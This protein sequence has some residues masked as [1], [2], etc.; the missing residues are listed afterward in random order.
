[1]KKREDALKMMKEWN[2]NQLNH[3]VEGLMGDW[4]RMNIRGS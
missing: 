2:Q 1:M 4:E 3:N